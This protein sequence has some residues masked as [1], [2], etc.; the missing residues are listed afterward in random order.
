MVLRE[1]IGSRRWYWLDK[2]E[3]EGWVKGVIGLWDIHF[4]K[5]K[6]ISKKEIKSDKGN[7]VISC[8]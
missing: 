5:S 7:L 4:L 6:I 2:K 8:F 3:R 1:E